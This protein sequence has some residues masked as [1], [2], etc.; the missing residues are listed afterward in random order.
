MKGLYM[1]GI[2]ERDISLTHQQTTHCVNCVHVDFPND[3]NIIT[4]LGRERPP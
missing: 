3:I 4:D 1:S 2:Y